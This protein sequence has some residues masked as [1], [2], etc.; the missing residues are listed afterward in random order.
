MFLWYA[1][2][3]TVLVLWASAAGYLHPSRLRSAVIHVR[4]DSLVWLAAVNAVILFTMT[5]RWWRIL[6]AWGLRISIGR[7][8]RY[9]IAAN[10][11]SYITPGSQFGGEPLQAYLLVSRENVPLDIAAAAVFL[12]RAMELALNLLVVAV[13]LMWMVR[14][15]SFDHSVGFTGEAF[16]WPN[17]GWMILV[18]AAVAAVFWMRR[19]IWNGVSRLPGG[20]WLRR[21]HLAALRVFAQTRGR[22]GEIFRKHPGALLAAGGLSL[23][24]W[25]FVFGEFR[26]LYGC[27]GEQ[28]TTSQVVIVLTAARLGLWVPVPGGMGAIEA[29]QLAAAHV[30]G[31][32]PEAAMGACLLMRLRDVMV[33]SAGVFLAGRYITESI[34]GNRNGCVEKEI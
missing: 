8:V 29:G 13:G 9:R 32:A 10:A 1:G 7:L 19:K 27:F 3:I 28:L 23:V 16:R 20:R 21:F 31:I 11:V 30:A 18:T 5:G 22:V 24:N 14:R 6:S 26:I 15:I 2:A 25:A 4:G 34:K 33:C 17:V 12:E